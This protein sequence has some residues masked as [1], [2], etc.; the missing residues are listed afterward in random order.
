M[1]INLTGSL[2]PLRDLVINVRV[3]KDARVQVG[4]KNVITRWDLSLIT[5]G[6]SH[7][8]GNLQFHVRQGNVECLIA[9]GYL[10]KLAELRLLYTGL[11]TLLYPSR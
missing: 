5:L 3:L 7:W 9:P 11:R 4:W 10:Q 2:E 8:L 6:P 1:N